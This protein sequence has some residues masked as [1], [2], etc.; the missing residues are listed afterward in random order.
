MGWVFAHYGDGW[1]GV[2]GDACPDDPYKF[3]PGVCGCGMLDTDNDGTPDCID[4]IPR[5]TEWGIIALSLLMLAVGTPYMR[6]RM[7]LVFQ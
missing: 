3:D 4:T 2:C 6:L 1:D 5:I 7:A